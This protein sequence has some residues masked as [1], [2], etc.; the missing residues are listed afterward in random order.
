MYESM[1]KAMDL[2]QKKRGNSKHKT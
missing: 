1:K 2:T